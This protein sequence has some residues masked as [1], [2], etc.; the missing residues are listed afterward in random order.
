MIKLSELKA[1]RAPTVSYSGMIEGAIERD[2]RPDLARGVL[3]TLRAADPMIEI[4]EA[5]LEWR[6]TLGRP[7]GDRAADVAEQRLLRL[8]GKVEL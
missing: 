5:A 7:R 1:V 2:W 4:I 6:S 8:L 3:A